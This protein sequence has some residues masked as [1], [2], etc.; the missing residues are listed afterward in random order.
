ME[1]HTILFT[2][3]MKAVD[4]FE[5]E[6]HA[7]LPDKVNGDD[8][9]ATYYQCRAHTYGQN[10]GCNFWWS[11][12]CR[13]VRTTLKTLRWKI[14]FAMRR[15]QMNK[16][17]RWMKLYLIFQNVTLDL[18]V[19]HVMLDQLLVTSYI[20]YRCYNKCH[21]W[22]YFQW[23]R[24]DEQACCTKLIVNKNW[25]KTQ[26]FIYAFHN[27]SHRPH[28]ALLVPQLWQFMFKLIITDIYL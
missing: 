20:E 25:S 17:C 2:S 19:R 4:D 26:R 22:A 18:D 16:K 23:W 14:Q 10:K 8:S 24:T 12:L 5:N 7:V 6:W 3:T 21:G 15:N 13:K 9:C 27:L 11:M 1:P 28:W